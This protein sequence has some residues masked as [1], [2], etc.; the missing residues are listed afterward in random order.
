MET[1]RL[2]FIVALLVNAPA[3]L[4]FELGPAALEIALVAGA[5]MTLLI[6]LIQDY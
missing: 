2:V 1:I 4:T 5:F 6:E 3:A